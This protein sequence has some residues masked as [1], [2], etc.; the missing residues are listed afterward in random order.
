[1]FLASD[2]PRAPRHPGAPTTEV[3]RQGAGFLVAVHDHLRAEL[4][5]VVRAVGLALTDHRRA[6][7]ARALVNDLQEPALHLQPQLRRTMETGLEYGAL[8]AIV[9]A[10]VVMGGLGSIWGALAASLLIGFVQ[11]ASISL[12][13]PLGAALMRMQRSSGATP[14]IRT[15]TSR[16]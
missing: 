14:G 16:A 1:M 4:A 10:I 11:T 2:R 9:F 8:G 12:D 6:A 3:G 5:Q 15:K 13:M 7:D